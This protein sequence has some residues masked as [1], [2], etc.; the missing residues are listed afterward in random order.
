MEMKFDK[1]R[2]HYD[3]SDTPDS[4][5]LQL[6]ECCRKTVRTHVNTVYVGT[7]LRIYNRGYGPDGQLATAHWHPGCSQYFI[8][9]L[10]R[11]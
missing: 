1:K 7:I 3:I 11:F 9:F 5:I 10:S 8:S 6:P 2:T 4:D